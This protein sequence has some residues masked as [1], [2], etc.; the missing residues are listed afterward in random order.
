[1]KIIGVEVGDEQCIILSSILNIFFVPSPWL[2]KEKENKQTS[3]N[4]ITYW[5]SPKYLT[6]EM[7]LAIAQNDGK[8]DEM[9]NEISFF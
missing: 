2:K 3:K 6:T 8:T 4:A 1:M 5:R 7:E 9:K